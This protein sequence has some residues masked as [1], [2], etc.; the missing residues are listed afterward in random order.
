MHFHTMI[1]KHI[2]MD[3]LPIDYQASEPT[4]SQIP[5]SIIIFILSI[6]VLFIILLIFN[7]KNK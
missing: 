1:T 5:M 3:V 6:F 4:E 2:L 7:G